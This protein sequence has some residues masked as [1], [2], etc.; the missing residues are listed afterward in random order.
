[1]PK[2]TTQLSSLVDFATLAREIAQDIFPV[3]QVIRLHN[4]TDEEWERI[5]Q[6][7]K[8]TSILADMQR[9]WNS[10]DNTAQRI[11]AKAQAGLETQIEILIADC[12]DPSIPL[13][14]RTEA[15]RVLA[16]LGDLDGQGKGN[17]AGEKFIIQLNIGPVETKVEVKDMP[18]VI[19]HQ[20]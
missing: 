12:G 15:Y 1:M 18:K 13:S 2:T 19:E 16:R 7:R 14:Q 8:F 9:E 20:P 11:K 3:E 17:V 5:S 4:L 6:H 10:A